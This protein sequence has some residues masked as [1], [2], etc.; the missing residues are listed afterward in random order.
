MDNNLIVEAQ[1]KFPSHKR[2]YVHV[3]ENPSNPFNASYWGKVIEMKDT[4]PKYIIYIHDDYLSYR[5]RTIK[6]FEPV[7]ILLDDKLWIE[8]LSIFDVVKIKKSKLKW[9]EEDKWT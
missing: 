4:D 3:K 9:E 5:S 7:R 8:L 1:K 2:I 6:N